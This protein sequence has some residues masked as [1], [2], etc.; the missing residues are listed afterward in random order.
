MR[1]T[2]ERHGTV[3]AIVYGRPVLF[4]GFVAG[5]TPPDILF[6]CGACVRAGEA[7]TL[8]RPL[9]D[10]TLRVAMTGEKEDKA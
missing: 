10:E 3:D 9:P 5:N 8:Q 7:L 6:L 4:S 1:G 2:L